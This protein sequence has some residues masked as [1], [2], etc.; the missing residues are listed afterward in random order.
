MWRTEFK[1]S[2]IF[3]QARGDG[4]LWTNGEDGLTQDH[5]ALNKQEGRLNGKEANSFGGGSL[6]MF[7]SG[8]FSALVK[9]EARSLR[10]RI[11]V[12]GSKAQ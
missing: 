1:N 8:S 4:V 9:Q 7:Y 11:Q 6:R 3:E 2:D 5:G 10:K 12:E